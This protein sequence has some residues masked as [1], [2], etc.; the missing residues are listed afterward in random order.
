MYDAHSYERLYSF[1]E[2]SLHVYDIAI[3]PDGT[4]LV[5]LLESRILI[6]DMIT[7]QK[8]GD[9]RMDEGRLTSV[10]ISK[11]SMRM[12]VGINENRI[13]M[14]SIDEGE[15][16]QVFEGHKQTQFIIRSAFGGAQE[17]FVVSGSEGKLVSDCIHR[18]TTC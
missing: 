2:G 10:S 6:F 18:H 5:A 17:T 4:R 12:L 13:K 1:K 9:W 15:T 14:M 7:R 3:S 16:L 11:D 8:I